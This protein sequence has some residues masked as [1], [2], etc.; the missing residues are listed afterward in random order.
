[1]SVIY[2]AFKQVYRP[3]I[4]AHPVFRQWTSALAVAD[5]KLEEETDR[6]VC[7]TACTDV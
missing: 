7:S 3:V 2:L 4:L 6:N 5:M 1:M